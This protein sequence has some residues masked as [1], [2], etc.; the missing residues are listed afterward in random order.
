MEYIEA[1]MMSMG[2]WSWLI[3]GLVFLGLE[4]L[5]PGTFILLWIGVAA[6]ITGL[7]SFVLPIGMQAQTIIFAIGS[8]I[9]VFLGRRYFTAHLHPSDR[10]LLNQRAAQ[11]IGQIYKV[12]EPIINGKGKV[13]I[14]DSQWMVQ[15]ED[16]EVGANVKVTSVKGNRLIVENVE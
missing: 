14:G 4:V 2:P 15:G 8:V 9:A 7:L 16:A 11:L 3:I 10:P 5:A 1:Y 13:K 12:S 6:I